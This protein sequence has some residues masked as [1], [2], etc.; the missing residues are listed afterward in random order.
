MSNINR[1]ADGRSKRRRP[2]FTP[3]QKW[4][5]ALSLLGLGLGLGNL[6]RMVMA[7]RYDALLPEL[8]LTVPLTYLAVMGG[9]WGLVFLT[10]AAGLAHFRQWGRWGPGD[11]STYA[12][13]EGY[14]RREKNDPSGHYF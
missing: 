1:N 9:L 5:L 6:V 10:C 13:Y 7:L 8:P 12:A 4:V 2:R 3:A 11:R 14:S